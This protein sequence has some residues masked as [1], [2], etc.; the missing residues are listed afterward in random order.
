MSFPDKASAAANG[1]QGPAGPP[2]FDEPF[3]LPETA[4]ASGM[5]DTG[6]VQDMFYSQPATTRAETT[7]TPL[8]L[9]PKAAHPEWPGEVNFAG[10]HEA[11]RGLADVVYFLQTGIRIRPSLNPRSILLLATPGTG[12]SLAR[13]IALE[14][15]VPLFRETAEDDEEE[16][17]ARLVSTPRMCAASFGSLP[18]VPP[19]SSSLMKLMAWVRPSC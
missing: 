12:L 4:M 9:D 6:G 2:R 14:A 3:S 13:A 7:K 11:L 1:G 5:P 17:D 18:G 16:A 19:A 10:M 8:A 15:G